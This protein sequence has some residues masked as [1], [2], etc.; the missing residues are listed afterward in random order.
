MSIFEKY[1]VYQ[2]MSDFSSCRS[3]KLS[4]TKIKITS[5]QEKTLINIVAI[6]FI[7]KLSKFSFSMCN[8]K[9]VSFDFYVIWL[10]CNFLHDTLFV[11]IRC[12]TF[13]VINS[14]NVWKHERHSL[15]IYF[16]LYW[17][18]YTFHYFMRQQSFYHTVIT[19]WGRK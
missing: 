1:I 2:M 18:K 17:L 12:F 5:S 11:R 16:Q 13:F 4:T 14:I 9:W 3:K 6:F 15:L 7:V 8:S 10:N 19:F